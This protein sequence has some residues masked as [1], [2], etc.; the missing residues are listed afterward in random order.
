MEFSL[1][2]NVLQHRKRVYQVML[3]NRSLVLTL[4]VS[5]IHY[6]INMPMGIFSNKVHFTTV[7][8]RSQS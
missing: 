1:I 6:F 4:T 8:S 3:D 2:E 5:H 7:L